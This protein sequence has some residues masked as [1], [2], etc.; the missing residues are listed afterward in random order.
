M[1]GVDCPVSFSPDGKRF[2]FVRGDFPQPGESS[3]LAANTDGTAES[4]IAARKLPERFYP[5]YFTGPSWSPDGKRIAIAVAGMAPNLR[6]K[7]IAFD[8]SDGTA[9][10][11]TPQEWET[12]GRVE[13][14]PDGNG[15]AMIAREISAAANQ[16]WFLSLADG[17]A[18]PITNDLSDYRSLSMSAD[19]TKLVTAQILRLTGAW[20][21]PISDP[22]N[23]RQITP[24]VDGG[25]V[26]LSWTPDG[27]LVHSA[28][29]VGSGDLWIMNP[30]GSGQ[31]QLTSTGAD[32]APSVSPDG[33]YITFLSSRSGPHNIWIAAI[34]GSEAR[35][36]AKGFGYANPVFTADS[37]WVLFA[38]QLPATAGV[39]KVPAAGGD[40]VRIIEGYYETP[41][42]SP[43][44]KYVAVKYVEN[45]RSVD[46]RPNKI[47]IFPIDGG[48]P[49]TSFELRPN[50]TIGVSYTWS[51]DSK[52]VIYVQVRDNVGN[53]WSQS[54]DGGQPK[55]LT[56]FT[57]GGIANVAVSRDGKHIALSRGTFTRDAILIQNAN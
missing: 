43:D 48:T 45:R 7:V 13:Y 55:Q 40:P 46:Q 3:L 8:V 35:E 26:S 9:T 33:R 56:N 53:L 37:T 50:E 1:E 34:D 28:G 47:A 57:D 2:A 31:K 54:I 38:S 22:V 44:G 29:V 32:R 10:E 20:V 30:D 27:K 11:L 4:V 51:P 19:A 42:T 21:A 49:L 15:I 36:L 5:N 25:I 14:M 17:H 16:V 39:W 18:R 23:G 24:M 6:S 52:S 12:I 41:I